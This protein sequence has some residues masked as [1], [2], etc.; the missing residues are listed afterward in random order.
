MRK[1]TVFMVLALWGAFTT[2]AK[3]DNVTIPDI[4]LLAGGTATMSIELNNTEKDYSAFQFY[5]SLPEGV[6]VVMENN[7]MKYELGERLKDTGFSVSTTTTAS[8]NYFVLGYY[9]VTQPIPEHSGAIITFTIQ[10]DENLAAGPL[11][12]QL[13]D[14]S[15]TTTDAEKNVYDCSFNINITNVITLDENSDTPPTTASGK[16]VIVR[17]TIKADEWSTICLPFA[18]T[19][20]QTKAAFG[21]D[22]EINDFTGCETTKNSDEEVTAI[23]VKFAPVTEMEANHPYVIKVSEPV[24]EF[25]VE[26]VDIEPEEEVS[27][28]RDE[29]VVI[30]KNKKYYFYNSFVGTYVANTEVPENSLFISEN[31]FWYSTGTAMMKAFRGYFDF[32][33][34]LSDVENAQS[35]IGF[36]FDFSTPDSI[37]ETVAEDK[38]SAGDLYS[39]NGVLIGKENAVKQLPK[40][41][42]IVKGKKVV[43]K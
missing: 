1:K 2:I 33:D 26:G 35:K 19:E 10:A 34:I 28:D 43:I 7:K 15:F 24:T 29:L 25:S 11:Q 22:V 20:E 12:G 13:F 4:T 31:K 18:M 36:S 14:S 5:F 6:S 3:A 21:D 41:V 38:N 39:I 16:D 40:G 27:L 30:I 17:R 42:Y 9:T 32:Y 23:L 8:G 37:K